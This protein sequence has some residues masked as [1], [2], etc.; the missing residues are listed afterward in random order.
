[1][2]GVNSATQPLQVSGVDKGKINMKTLIIKSLLT[3]LCKREVIY[4]SLAKRGK[5]RFP[6]EC[7]FP[8]KISNKDFEETGLIKKNESIIMK[9]RE[10]FKTL[11]LG[12]ILLLF[13]KKVHA[14]KKREDHLKEAMFWK[15]ID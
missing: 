14:E 4:P 8:C 13:G 11:F 9:R 3:S 15:K 1:M 5:E 7:T 12:G 2:A 10:F 6:H